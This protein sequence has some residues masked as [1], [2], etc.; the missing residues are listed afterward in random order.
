MQKQQPIKKKKFRDLSGVLLLDKT[1]DISSNKAL[2]D[3]RFL[4]QAKKAGHTGTLDPF[5]TGL[6]PICFGQANKFSRW[7]LG[8][9]KT[10]QF[11]I[12]LGVK[13]TTADP[14]GEI[15]EEKPIPK[16]TEKDLAQ[17][18]TKFSGKITQTPPKYSALKI[19]GQRAYKL[20]R[21]GKEVIIKPRQVFVESLELSLKDDNLITGIATVSKGTYI[22][23][24]VED[25]AEQLGTVGYCL[26]LRR[27]QVANLLTKKDKMATYTELS[28]FK[29][30]FSKLDKYLLPIDTLCSQFQKI[31]ISE[32]DWSL[33]KCGKKIVQ[34][35]LVSNLSPNIYKM[36][37]NNRFLGLGEV[38]IE[39]IT[40]EEVAKEN[41][42]LKVFRL[43]NT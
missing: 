22:R 26:N 8:A 13:R 20:A 6:L 9:K 29:D 4:F 18:I 1:I 27:K 39:E 40:L 34:S 25:I 32:K 2:Q 41:K 17:V 28:Q 21:A 14:E 16:L 11:T 31:N 7:L 23:V 36:Y 3:A 35:K 33:L 30:D 10:Y 15:I 43:I 24:L 42:I 37:L 12:F 5:A 19:D 38:I